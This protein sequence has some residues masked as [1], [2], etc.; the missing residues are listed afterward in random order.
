MKNK[1]AA[2]IQP[3]MAFE[4]SKKNHLL[5]DSECTN[6]QGTSTTGFSKTMKMRMI[7]HSEWTY[8]PTV[9]KYG[10]VLTKY[11]RSLIL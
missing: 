2:L 8:N 3:E 10:R 4:R 5:V 6:E 11:I 7:R 1:N 9:S